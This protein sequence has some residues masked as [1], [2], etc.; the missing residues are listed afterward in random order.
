MWIFALGLYLVHLDGGMLRLAGIFGFASGGCILLFG[1]LV[2]E[3]VD[4][5]KRLYVLRISLGTM[6]A[7]I[8]LCSAT[9]CVALHLEAS[10]PDL[11]TGGL[12]IFFE[13]AIV[14]LAIIAQL[15][16]MTYKIMLE[17]DWMVVVAH[18]DT[19]AL[20]N[21]NAVTRCV[22]LSAK[23]VA[24]LCVGAV[25]TYISL[26]VSAIG[27]AVWNVLSVI[28]EYLLLTRVYSL[29]PELSKKKLRGSECS[30]ETETEMEEREPMNGETKSLEFKKDS[31]EHKPK[32]NCIRTMFEPFIVLVNG[33]RTYIRQKVVFAGLALALLYMT[34]MGFDSV[35][36]GY[37]IGNGISES[38]V[39]IIMALGGLTGILATFIYPCMR[40]KIGLSKTGM[41]AFAGEVFCL[42]L[43]VVSI[44]LPGSPFDMNFKNKPFITNCTAMSTGRSIGLQT[45]ALPDIVSGSLASSVSA[46]NSVGDIECVEITDAPDGPNISI[47]VFLIG[48]I[49]SRTGLWLA[50]LVVTQLLQ[51]NVAETERGVVNGVQ[52]SINMLLEMIKFVLV[53]ILP[54]VETFGILVILS[55]SFIVLAGFLFTFYAYR[56]AK[57]G[58]HAVVLD[59]E[60]QYA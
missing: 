41:I 15:A 8:L 32:K 12:K 20:A 48:I 5:N 58:S 59:T 51:E 33:W 34:V 22:D 21:L 53:M 3:W 56:N 40:R 35:T 31:Q 46:S 39:G 13:V 17:R 28:V 54:H 14:T 19:S 42:I 7:F 57:T 11:W 4:R 2:G 23:I 50:D 38:E 37:I 49:A 1:G 24:P 16:N 36:V 30:Y 6:N 60:Q 44:W 47:I 26:L 9:V 25:M 18:G 55:F 52:N 45:T 43:A 27:I 29:V 10:R